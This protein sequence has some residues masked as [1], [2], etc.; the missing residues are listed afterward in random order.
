MCTFGLSG[1]RVKPRRPRSLNTTHFTLHT[2][3]CTLHTVHC[4]LHTAHTTSHTTSHHIT[5]YRIQTC[6]FERQGA[7]NT[8]KIPRKDPQER[9][10]KN[11]NCGG[12]GKIKR[13]IFGPPTLRGPTP[14]GP[15]LRAPTF[16]GFGPPPFGPPPAPLRA[17][18]FSGFG[19]PPF[20]PPTLLFLG[21]GPWP[22]KKNQTIKNHK[23]KQFK[24][25]QTINFRHLK[26]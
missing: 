6:T 15:T 1:C 4:T 14:R 25:I 5:S 2:A 9:E 18:T 26:P 21:L 3:L 13:E 7:S 16:S 20:G 23:K 10:E 17:S 11:G 22:A 12:R 19:P 24:K 8:T